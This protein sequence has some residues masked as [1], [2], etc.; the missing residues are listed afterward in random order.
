MPENYN[1]LF[2]YLKKEGISIDKDEFEFQVQSHPDYPSLL[3]ISDTLSFFNINNG[4]TR[5]AS[6]EIELLPE[7]FIAF[8]RE[9]KNKLQLCFIEKK[10]SE[11]VYTKDKKSLIISKQDLETRWENIVLLV[12]KSEIELTNSSN[13]L[14]WITPIWFLAIFI[15][16]LYQSVDNL[17]TKLFF[18]FPIL[19]ILFSVAALKDLF[20]T[21]SELLNSFCNMTAST[22]CTDIVS[23]NK[24][25][26]FKFV[27]FSDLSIIFF[28]SQFIG[29][30]LFLFTGNTVVFFSIQKV[31]IFTAAPILFLSLYYQKFVEKKWCPICLAIITVIFLELCYV[32]FFQSTAF[33]IL[34]KSLVIMSFVIASVTLVW[35]ILKKLLTLQKEL[36]EFQLKG[37][38]FMRN[39]E[40]FKNALL[41]S[42]RVENDLLNVEA[43]VLG[44]TEA[45]LRIIVVTSPFCGYCKEAHI[46]IEEILQK[47]HN[48][49]CVDIRFNFN[50]EYGDEKSKKIH[51]QLVAIY[52]DQ[53]Q[54]AFS[55]A[56][57]SWFENKEEKKLDGLV[58]TEYNTLKIN[59]ILEKQF[60][61][62]KKNGIN[63]TPAIIIN[64]F[65]FPKQYETNELIHFIAE[66][67]EDEDFNR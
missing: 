54:A 44:N 33:K 67:S 21:K 26:I 12:E 57:H 37:S 60:N 43:I 20:G 22:S 65:V 28:S 2:Q 51:Q 53:G 27:N 48:T 8:L 66:L 14:S 19:G 63:Y 24:W 23:S 47:H 7:R 35:L 39:Y 32:L 9:E 64:Q 56:L 36:K 31:L 45:P 3:S 30:L 40:I 52:Y 42:N 50:F 62:N 29:L 6:S 17:Q 41:A 10:G 4:A 38:R 46:I 58:I 1:Y 5:L 25:K 49:V 34:L 16:V 13:K 59:M 11:Y 55:K 18:L 15:L 61:W